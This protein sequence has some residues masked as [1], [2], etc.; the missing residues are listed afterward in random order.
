MKGKIKTLIFIDTCSLLASCWNGD[1]RKG[2]TIEYDP[3]KEKLLRDYVWN[4]IA[5]GMSM[6]RTFD[7]S[8]LNTRKRRRSRNVLKSIIS[9]TLMFALAAVLAVPCATAFAEDPAPLP[10][11]SA[12]KYNIVFVIDNSGSTINTDPNLFRK[13][14]IDYFLAIMADSGNIVGGIVFQETPDSS[15]GMVAINSSADKQIVSQFFD[16][17]QR[18]GATD[19]GAAVFYATQMLAEHGNPNLP[20]A[21]ILMTDGR[22]EDIS[23]IDQ[24]FNNRD[25]AINTAPPYKEGY[26]D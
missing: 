25:T 2:E 3:A 8:H 1:D 13:E 20:S 24:S 10:T 21:I 16:L 23:S 7:D 6:L 19:I 11:S 5:K 12:H 26:Y 9:V 4:A 14:A 18:P 17:P 22:T 15:L